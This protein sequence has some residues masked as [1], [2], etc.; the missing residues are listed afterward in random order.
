MGARRG[1]SNETVK[2]LVVALG[3]VLLVFS[4]AVLGNEGATGI[5]KH[6]MDANLFP[7]PCQRHMRTSRTPLNRYVGGHAFRDL[8]CSA[9]PQ[10]NDLHVPIADGG[11]LFD[12][13][14]NPHPN[15]YLRNRNDSVAIRTTIPIS[16]PT[17]MGNAEITSIGLPAH[18]CAN[19]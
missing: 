11:G 4:G 10:Q 17:A 15:I 6:R 7:Q 3:A 19:Q 9:S 8:E 12:T 2:R 5:V 18:Q 13:R 16:A 1:S 14:A